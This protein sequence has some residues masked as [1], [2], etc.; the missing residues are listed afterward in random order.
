MDV[1]KQTGFLYFLH[2]TD[3]TVFAVNALLGS[4]VLGKN[5][6]EHVVAPENAEILQV[7]A[8]TS[9]DVPQSETE[10]Y[11]ESSTSSTSPYNQETPPVKMVKVMSKKHRDVSYE[12]TD[13]TDSTT[14]QHKSPMSMVKVLFNKRRRV[15]KK[16][17]I[18]TTVIP[19][20]MDRPQVISGTSRETPHIT[21]EVVHENSNTASSSRVQGEPPVMMVE[22]A[23]RKH[24]LPETDDSALRPDGRGVI[25]ESSSEIQHPNQRRISPLLKRLQRRR[26]VAPTEVMGPEVYN[27]YSA[28][29]TDKKNG[30]VG[31]L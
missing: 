9:T 24:M 10:V 31:I 23:S 15:L 25:P 4:N 19:L 6:Q 7:R 8:D 16:R 12:T 27:F 5:T 2:E 14:D 17:C 20:D 1:L 18:K 22:V 3:I 21:T 26:A 29:T 28:E 30:M 13:S 11:P